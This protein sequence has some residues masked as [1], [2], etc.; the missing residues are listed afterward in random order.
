[1]GLHSCAQWSE[2][3]PVSLVPATQKGLDWPLGEPPTHSLTYGRAL[4]CPPAPQGSGAAGKEGRPPPCG[5]GSGSRQTPA[6]SPGLAPGSAGGR[7]GTVLGWGAGT[8]SWQEP[9]GVG[10]D[11]QRVA[12]MGRQTQRRRGLPG[13][14]GEGHRLWVG[15]VSWPCSGELGRSTHR[16]PRNVLGSWGLGCTGGEGSAGLT[17]AAKA[18]HPH[19]ARAVVGS[20]AGAPSICPSVSLPL[21]LS[22]VQPG[23]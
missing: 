15:H 9:R 5:L 13:A 21:S 3:E 18:Q 2:P 1:M 14:G 19:P 23:H 12:E 11:T 20:H 8:E 6:P 7:P 10:T 4:T 17:E 16:S 22:S